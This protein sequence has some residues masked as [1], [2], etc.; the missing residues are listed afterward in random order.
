MGRLAGLCLALAMA[1]FSGYMFLR[2]G[3]WVALLFLVGSLAYTL[4]FV[5]HYR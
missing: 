3:D 4:F 2:T 1:G 5:V